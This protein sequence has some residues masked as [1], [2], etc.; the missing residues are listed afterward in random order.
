MELKT[1]GKVVVPAKIENLKDLF[2]ADEGIIP[3]D[4]I[5]SVEV[6]DA[7]VDTGATMLA[8]PRSLIA[9]LGLKRVR[10]RTA[11][12]TNGVFQFG[13]YESVRLTVRGRDCAIEV[14]E[15]PEDCPVLIGQAPLELLDW[16]VDPNG[17]KLI[18]NPDH[19][20]EHMFDLF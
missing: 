17:Q 4:Q 2:N 13:I 10:T 18:G 9:G 11:R 1:M 3:S 12:T 15:L 5:R 19:N 6:L 7:L 14:A 16:V 8:M 20:G